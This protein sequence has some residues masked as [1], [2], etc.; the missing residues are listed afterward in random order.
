[1]FKNFDFSWFL[2]TPGILTG[3]G[4]LLI[5]ISIIIFLSLILGAKYLGFVGVLFAPAIAAMVCVLLNE[6]YVNNI[7][8]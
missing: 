7:K 2:T 6:L 4:C 1:M 5:L 8:D 3:V